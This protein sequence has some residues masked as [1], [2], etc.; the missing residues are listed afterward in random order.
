M[1][2]FFIAFLFLFFVNKLPSAMVVDIT[3]GTVSEIPIALTKLAT[4]EESFLG[5][6][7]EEEVAR[8]I[9][10]VVS[11]NLKSSGLFREI[12]Q[13]AFIQTK[14]EKGVRFNDWR[15]I[16]AQVLVTG[17][18]NLIDDQTFSIEFHVYDVFSQE[19]LTTTTFEAEVSNWRRAAHKMSDIIY[20]RV[21]GEKGYFDTRIV[22]I[23][24]G[25]K[26]LNKYYTRL[27]VMDQDG[28]NHQYLTDKS[29]LVLTPRFSPTLH[30]ITYMSYGKNWKTPRVHIMNTFNGEQKPLGDFKGMTYAPRFTPDGKNV[31]M[32]YSKNGES[33]LYK[34]NIKSGS[35]K[36]LTFGPSIDVSGCSSPDGK[37]IV[38]NSDR[39]GSQQL[40][41]MNDSGDNIRRISFGKG[42]YAS[43]V[44]S[45]RGDLIAF[46]KIS[47]G[48]FYIGVMRADGSGE[49]LITSGY[50]V[51]EPTWAP[52]GRVL[53]Y[54]R[55]NTEN[56]QQKIYRID[57]TGFNDKQIKTP[58]GE[59]AI[60]AAWSPLL[61]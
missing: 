51:E 54:S 43:P 45:P 6:S 47:A 13:R 10:K 58:K 57:L 61:P 4:K 39:E 19:E 24:K 37:K 44:W 48:Q 56:S 31:L 53:I 1:I 36:Q 20:E 21:T 23:A 8:S 17:K 33:C 15:V 2:R 46:T 35:M 30:H 27:A 14:F 26:G 60:C 22:Y 40:Y 25:E 41:I 42:R 5:S 11:Y 34:R 12:D 18:V 59:E 55:K 38:F 52:N 16:N 32:S 50:L 3:K 7:P 49:R 29:K 9:E 28:E